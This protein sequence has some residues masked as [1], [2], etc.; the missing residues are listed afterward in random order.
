MAWEKFCKDEAKNLYLYPDNIYTSFQKQTATKDY[1]A[2]ETY[3]TCPKCLSNK[4]EISNKQT[5]RCD[6][7]ETTFYQCTNC[8][9]RWT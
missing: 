6:E 9:N 5:R 1:V 4:I 7:S 3:I 2:H 8:E